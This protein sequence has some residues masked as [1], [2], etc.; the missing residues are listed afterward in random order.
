MT[1]NVCAT[2]YEYFANVTDDELAYARSPP[3]MR[4]LV[5]MAVFLFVNAHS[6]TLEEILIP[7][8]KDQY[9]IGLWSAPGVVLALQALILIW[10]FRFVNKD[11]SVTSD[12][13]EEEVET[14]A[15]L[16]RVGL[17]KRFE[18]PEG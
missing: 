10:R 8:T 1:T 17:K 16:R 13:D 12:D 9:L 5:V 14:R 6:S 18:Y 15:Q 3:S 11:E 2:L 4:C 7:I